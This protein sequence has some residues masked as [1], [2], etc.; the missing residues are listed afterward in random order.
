MTDFLDLMEQRS[1]EYAARRAKAID[2]VTEYLLVKHNLVR[3]VRYSPEN[4]PKIKEFLDKKGFAL[5]VKII[6]S[7]QG[8]VIEVELLKKVDSS[9]LFYKHPTITFKK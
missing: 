4:A 1:E 8:E 7:E 6:T 9:K 2:E 5:N 3:G